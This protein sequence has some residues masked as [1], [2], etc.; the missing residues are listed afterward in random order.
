MSKLFIW[1]CYSYKIYIVFDHSGISVPFILLFSL[2]VSLW[3]YVQVL[4]DTFNPI[5]FTMC[6]ETHNLFP[7]IYFMFSFFLHLHLPSQCIPYFSISTSFAFYMNCGLSQMAAVITFSYLIIALILHH[8]L[9]FS[10]LFIWSGYFKQG[11][12]VTLSCTMP[13]SV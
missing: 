9:N 6:C 3:I 11:L 4:H 13:C 5:H 10:A 12:H 1:I 8:F 7:G 2:L